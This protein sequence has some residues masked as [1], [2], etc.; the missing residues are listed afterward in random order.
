MGNN[1]KILAL[2]GIRSEYDILY[3]ILAGL[4]KKKFDLSIAVSGAHLSHNFGFTIKKIESDGFQIAD[5]IDSL[6]STDREVQRSK[7][8]GALVIGL[9]QTVERIRPDILIVVGDRE[10]SIAAAIVG[11]YFGILIMHIGGGDP[12]FGNTDDP[13][14]FAVSKLS[15]IH[16][17]MH[18]EYAK[19]LLNIGEE[20]FRIFNTGNPSYTNIDNVGFIK[21]SKLFENLGI[22]ST[23]DNF[24][25]LIQHPLSS[26]VESTELQI[27]TTLEALKDFCCMHN[28]L[29]VCISPNSDPG[30]EVIR[31]KIRNFIK[32]DWFFYTET[33]TRD[34]FVNLMRH[35]KS[36]IG[37][38]SM[39]VLEAPHYKLPVVNVGNRQKGRLNAGNV[40]FVDHCKD[41][42]INEI[43]RAC[44]DISYRKKIK[45]LDNPYGDGNSSKKIIKI[46]NDINLNESRWLNKRK[47]VP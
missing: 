18:E 30:S 27:D 32:E 12:A 42:I 26:E 35:A 29:T 4:D 45:T 1:K 11:N 39:G 37:N 7:A 6:F 13:I 21:Q 43:T 34:M 17:V 33:L 38:S 25:V 15:H 44:L 28:Y 46:I 16:C 47:L 9:T 24:I 10:E 40:I 20:D 36:L 2:T 3:P 14:R 22:K 41:K 23:K 19:N 5:R 8:V 31:E